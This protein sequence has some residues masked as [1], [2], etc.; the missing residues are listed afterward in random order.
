MTLDDATGMEKIKLI[1]ELDSI[2]KNMGDET[3]ANKLKSVKRIKEIR[4]ILLGNPVIDVSSGLDVKSPTAFVQSLKSWVE[5]NLKDFPNGLLLAEKVKIISTWQLIK[6]TD[7]SDEITFDLESEY[8]DLVKLIPE[9]DRESDYLST[10]NHFSRIGLAI[11]EDR[12]Y[13]VKN[14]MDEAEGLLKVDPVADPETMA[15]L[16]EIEQKIDELSA[17][18]EDILQIKENLKAKMRASGEMP[19]DLGYEIYNHPDYKALDE[20]YA[21]IYYER[22]AIFDSGS[23]LRKKKWED[24]NQRVNDIRAK[25]A[26]VGRQILDTLNSKSTVSDET[27]KQFADNVSID[28]SILTRLKKEG[29]DPKQLRQDIAE[30]Y[31]VTGGKLRHVEMR[32]TGVKRAHANNIS[33]FE[34]NYITPGSN[35]NKTTLWHELAHHLEA[36]P[37]ARMAAQG[38]LIKRRKSEEVQQL[39]VL[40][41]R[42]YGSD[43]YAYEDEFINPYIGKYYRHGDTEVFA[44]GVQ[45]LASAEDAAAFAA[46][47]PEMFAMVTGYL[48]SELTPAMKTLQVVQNRAKDNS[49]DQRNVFEQ[50]YQAAIKALIEDMEIENDGWFDALD[51]DEKF[52]VLNRGGGDPEAKFIGSIGWYRIFQGKFKKYGS[53]R[54]AK[55]YSV[56]YENRWG[57]RD[58]SR[59][60]KPIVLN[61]FVP[62]HE[63]LELL[64]AAIKIAKNEKNNQLY[65]SVYLFQSKYDTRISVIEAAQKITGMAL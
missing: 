5:N 30:F 22:Q 16:K 10:F 32:A 43:E 39:R 50:R 42:G 14:I 18:L 17:R 3:G 29:Y 61:G 25:G 2:R 37:A 33:H 24:R 19:T 49:Q 13:Y 4:S 58:L 62:F 45:Y 36:D 11:D 8:I 64:K 34:N 47:D 9:S 23:P 52:A 59:E 28:K 21:K 44:M 41:H 6:K 55:G 12:R 54:I 56:T 60:T 40:A 20:E 26:E 63:S 51:D 53:R 27:A 65:N 15:K 7:K 57:L 1:R 38:F 35:F 46:K 31:K 48:T